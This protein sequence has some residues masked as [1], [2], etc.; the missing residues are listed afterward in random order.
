M[1]A[2]LRLCDSVGLARSKD[3]ANGGWIDRTGT[4]HPAPSFCENLGWRA[5]EDQ[6]KSARI[7]LRGFIYIS[8]PLVVG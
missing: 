1:A 3:Q 4:G 2:I 6:T 7:S 8:S 5:E